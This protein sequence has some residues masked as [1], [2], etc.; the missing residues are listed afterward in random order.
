[1]ACTTAL[2]KLGWGCVGVAS[3]AAKDVELDYGSSLCASDH[4]RQRHRRHV[5]RE[6]PKRNG[7]DLVV[8]QAAASNVKLSLMTTIKTLARDVLTRRG[9]GLMDL[10]LTATRDWYPTLTPLMADSDL[11]AAFPGERC[12]GP[13]PRNSGQIGLIEAAA[14]P[15]ADMVTSGFQLRARFARAECH[16]R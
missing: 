2:D 10:A 4:C 5:P 6:W 3:N 8:L 15:E 13:D 16:P 1:M 7:F 12:A 11:A 14:G 9:Q